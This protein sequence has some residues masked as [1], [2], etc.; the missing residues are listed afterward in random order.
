MDA[1]EVQRCPINRTSGYQAR[2]GGGKAKQGGKENGGEL[3]GKPKSAD[4]AV[5]VSDSRVRVP[6]TSG[7]G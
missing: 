1:G 2:S 5:F 4:A 7:S 3:L 6:M